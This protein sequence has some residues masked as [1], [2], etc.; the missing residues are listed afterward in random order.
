MA[1]I[2]NPYTLGKSTTMSRRIIPK[3][4]EVEI[5]P[6]MCEVKI[7]PKMCEVEIRPKICEVGINLKYFRS[8]YP[9]T[10]L[11]RIKMSLSHPIEHYF[12]PK[13][14]TFSLPPILGLI[15]TSNG[16][17]L[18]PTSTLGLIPI[19]HLNVLLKYVH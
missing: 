18:I 3:T 1:T 13:M 5:R 4:C 14:L 15:P 19:P 9:S 12:K 2:L 6:K 8:R 16:L 17:G 10:P 7:R 11:L